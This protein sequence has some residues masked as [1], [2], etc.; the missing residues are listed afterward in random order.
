MPVSVDSFILSQVLG[1]DA[2]HTAAGIT[3][4]TILCAFTVPVWITLMDMF[5]A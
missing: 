1:M 2:D 4:S 3:A 5:L